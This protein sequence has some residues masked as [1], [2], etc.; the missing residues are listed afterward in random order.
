MATSKKIAELTFDHERETKGTHRYAE[1]GDPD[2][3]AVGTLYIRK[4]QLD[5]ERPDKIK[6]VITAQS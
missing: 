3:L 4:S 1:Q 6:V 5:G 2:N